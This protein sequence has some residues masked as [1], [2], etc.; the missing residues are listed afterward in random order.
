MTIVVNGVTC[1]VA[2]GF[3]VADIVAMVT[4]GDS[5][6]VAV[7]RNGEVVRRAAW[8]A[9]DVKP[10]DAFEVLHAVAGG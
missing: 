7:A 2:T 1:D 5:S 4:S 10:G 3:V 8:G 9:T 6:G